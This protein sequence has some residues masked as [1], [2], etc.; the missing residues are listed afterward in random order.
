[1]LIQASKAFE[2]CVKCHVLN[3][4]I[5]SKNFRNECERGT[6]LTGRSFNPTLEQKI[7]DA[8]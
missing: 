4:Q 6:L 1:M 7:L 5:N 2:R 8:L 3:P